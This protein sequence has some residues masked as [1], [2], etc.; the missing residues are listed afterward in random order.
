M[1]VLKQRSGGWPGRLFR[2]FLRC[3]V[4]A[5]L[6]VIAA[7]LARSLVLL[8]ADL[9]QNR[10]MMALGA[11]FAGGVLVFWRVLRLPRLYVFGHELTHWLAALVFR[12]RT[13]GFR[14]GA[15]GGS[16]MVERPNLW[17]VLAPYFIPVYT[18]FWVGLYGF[19]CLVRGS[20]G[21]GVVA[22]TVAYAGVG[23]TYAFHVVWTISAL[24]TAQSDLRMY[25]VMLSLL[26]I[27]C[28][29]LTFVYGGMV[30]AT[31]RYAVGAQCIVRGTEDVL[32][33]LAAGLRL[34][35]GAVYRMIAAGSS[36]LAR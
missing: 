23:V 18:L 8:P 15:G 16:V 35:G 29:N 2:G 21:P 17:I 27:V 3:I 4:N 28:F 6:A 11:G 36:R 24:R 30:A 34:L 32:G 1:N 5:V 22:A 26:V 9:P 14:A 7:S 20:P 19:Y 12:R 33:V 25:G 31:R 13:A 10:G